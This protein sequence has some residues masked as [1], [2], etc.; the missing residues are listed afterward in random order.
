MVQSSTYNPL[1]SLA[2]SQD[3]VS[4]GIKFPM[5]MAQME[6]DLQTAGLK[7][8]LATREMRLREGE[9]ERKTLQQEKLRELMGSMQGASLRQQAEMMMRSG[10]PELMQQGTSMFNAIKPP[11]STN[12]NLAIDNKG[13]ESFS[14]KAGEYLDNLYQQAQGASSNVAQIDYAMDILKSDPKA[15]SGEFA[16]VKGKISSILSDLGVQADQ[17][18]K[19]GLPK[20]SDFQ[21]L[22]RVLTRQTLEEAKTKALGSGVAVSNK[23]LGLYKEVAGKITDA[24]EAIMTN[25]R[26]RK[27]L[28]KL[29]QYKN[30]YVFEQFE[31]TGSPIKSLRSFDKIKS[32]SPTIK[33][34]GKGKDKK[35]ITFS[36]FYE[37]IKAQRGGDYSLEEGFKDFKGLN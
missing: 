8:L 5:Q 20:A 2:R 15:L 10:V 22:N 27:N 33:L 1:L 4:S 18:E 34:I 9:F 21:S 17:Q 7:N 26:F 30:D 28:D 37:N 14:K 23:D 35:M 24:P 16:G 32:G 19:M 25:L 6:Q 29:T 31:K 13:A 11:A 3:I 12:I 36:E